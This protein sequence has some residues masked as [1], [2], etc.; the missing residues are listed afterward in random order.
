MVIGDN[1][2]GYG[3]IK[4]FYKFK[5]TFLIQSNSFYSVDFYEEWY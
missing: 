5:I 1:E 3:Q 2:E 4:V